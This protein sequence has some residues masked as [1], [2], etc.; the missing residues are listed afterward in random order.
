MPDTATPPNQTLDVN[1]LEQAWRSAQRYL[2]NQRGPEGFWPGHLSNSALS[3]ATATMA[4]DESIKLGV[5]TDSQRRQR[6]ESVDAGWRWLTNTQNPDGGW[7]DTTLSLSNISTTALVWAALPSDDP[8]F[9]AANNAAEQWLLRAVNQSL[10]TRAETLNARDLATAIGRRYGKDHTFSVPILTALALRGRL[11]KSPSAWR[12]IPQLPFEFAAFPRAWYAKLRLRVVSYAL[13]ALIAIGLVRFA[14]H[15]G[16][17]LA[18]NALRHLVK[19]RVLQILQEIQPASGGFLEA[20][21]LTSFVTLGLLRAGLESSPVVEAGLAF[22]DRSIRDDGSWPI[23]TNL[24][25]WATT[26]SINSLREPSSVGTLAVLSSSE[27]EVLSS[28]LLGQQYREVHPFTQAA[29]GGWAWTDLSGGVPDADD[30]PGALLALSLLGQDDPGLG[31]AA[32][33]GVDWLLGTQNRD[34]GMPTFCRGWGQLPFDRSSAD[35]TAHALRAWQCWGSDLSPRVQGRLDSAAKRSI[36]YLLQTQLASGAWVPLWFGNQHLREEENPVYGTSRVLLAWVATRNLQ[37]VD[38]EAAAL[39]AWGWLLEQQNSDGG[40]GG[41]LDFDANSFPE[42]PS[43]IEETGLAIE[44]LTQCYVALADQPGHE[45]LLERTRQALR[46]G[47]DR[48][49]RLTENGTSFPAAPIG[50][51]FAKLWYFESTYPI[52]FALNALRGLMQVFGDTCSEPR[53]A[54]ST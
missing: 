23:D 11:G 53:G 30:T 9:A 36:D 21:P 34:G 26:L 29:P 27:Q 25:T 14:H 35:L 12:L 46:L 15:R 54:I 51:Y 28:W 22:L 5:G 4:F 2:L 6:R 24:A 18:A 42:M 48:L 20:T 38:W 3:T 19:S 8:R 49:L 16:W 47:G 33:R 32:E 43:S 40:W 37:R 44:A 17:N 52:V 45:T 41:G 50:F 13:P 7:G 31:A 10:G 1:R 39:R